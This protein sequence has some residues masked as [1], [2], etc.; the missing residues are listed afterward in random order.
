MSKFLCDVVILEYALGHLEAV[1]GGHHE[2]AEDE[3]GHE[4]LSPL[5]LHREGGRVAVEPVELQALGHEDGLRRLLDQV[6][7][8]REEEEFYPG[9]EGG[10]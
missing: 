9:R 2:M 1:G 8:S 4:Y 5:L 10:V 7:R 3:A 6:L